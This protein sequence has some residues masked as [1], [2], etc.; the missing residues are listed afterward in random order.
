[1]NARKKAILG[2][3]A[4]M[5]AVLAAVGFYYWYR[6]T[7]FVITED[8]RVDADKVRVSPQIAGKLIELKVEEG[9]EVK[10]GE[11]IGRQSDV[12]LPPGADPDLAVIRSPIS[13]TVIRKET[14]VGEVVAP[15]QAVVM[16]ADLREPYIT[17]NIEETELSKIRPG[18]KVEFTIDA[19]PGHVFTGRVDSIGE[20]TLSTF[21]LFSSAGTSGTF[22]KVVQRVPVKI[23][24][25]NYRGQRVL[26]GMNAVVK[27]YVR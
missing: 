9:D 19:V 16:V 10:A 4:A 20:A 21:S 18:Q 8:A 5:I 22:T 7:H 27:I 3:L 1:M 23:I 12:A 2:G 6:S 15:G 11:I 25:D 24:F 17:A 26:P 13:G 14:S